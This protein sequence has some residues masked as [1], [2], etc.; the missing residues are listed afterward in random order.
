MVQWMFDM[1]ELDIRNENVSL[2]QFVKKINNQI[3]IPK[4]ILANFSN[5]FVCQ[6][7]IIDAI[8]F[9][10]PIMPFMLIENM[11][12]TKTIIDGCKRAIAIK[13]FHSGILKIS[14]LNLDFESLANKYKNRFEDTS[15]LFYILPHRTS[16]FD[17]SR[18]RGLANKSFIQE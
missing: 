2:L 11:D 6:Q 13:N 12:G 17:I 16:S 14:H 7:E 18:L 1:Y 9:G 15:I 3:I 10:F 4:D 5:R 8:L